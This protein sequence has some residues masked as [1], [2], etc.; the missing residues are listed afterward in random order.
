MKS[1]RVTNSLQAEM[2]NK[3]KE[4]NARKRQGSDNDSPKSNHKAGKRS[5]STAVSDN[6]SN[7]DTN[8]N[9]SQAFIKNGSE[10][11]KDTQA[12]SNNEGEVNADQAVAKD[13]SDYM[14][15]HRQIL[16]VIFS[17]SAQE[18]CVSF[19]AALRQATGPLD[20]GSNGIRVMARGD[21]MVRPANIDAYNRLMK[22]V[23]DPILLKG[24][25]GEHCTA[26]L[27]ARANTNGSSS[28]A[29][30]AP[31]ARPE[32]PVE[33]RIVVRSVPAAVGTD[34]EIFES[35]VENCD[36]NQK[37]IGVKRI[38]AKGG[39]PTPLLIVEVGSETQVKSHLELGINILFCHYKCV[40]YQERP[41]PVQCKRCLK[42]GQ[43]E[44]RKCKSELKCIRCGGEHTVNNCPTERENAKCSNCGGNHV[45]VYKGCPSYKEARNHMN[46][47]LRTA[48]AAKGKVSGKE[49]VTVQVGQK[50]AVKV[51]AWSQGPPKAK[52]QKEDAASSSSITGVECIR[53][54]VVTAII[55]AAQEIV[56]SGCVFTEECHTNIMKKL[57]EIFLFSS[58]DVA[59]LSRAVVANN[60]EC[61]ENQDGQ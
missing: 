11:S 33:H 60:S 22:L 50:A 10:S 23:E 14:K 47:N 16:P 17:R 27:P 7:M 25:L 24:S 38:Y 5:E 20:L 30:R 54:Q 55:A 6:E 21:F 57:Q 29:S 4:I 19:Y 8:A 40:E 36:E 1:H 49:I 39:R 44:A 61:P 52:A 37:F 48:Q 18:T 41:E 32:K 35:L 53:D 59:R 3:K 45:A 56:K 26:K 15:T 31:S 58:A 13:G 51:N 12:P 42:W 46:A 9:A 34:S 43:H 28:N 2:V